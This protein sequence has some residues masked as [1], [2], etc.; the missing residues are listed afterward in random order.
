MTPF[1][2]EFVAR[3]FRFFSNFSGICP[4]WGIF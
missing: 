2:F 4:E 3:D 1:D